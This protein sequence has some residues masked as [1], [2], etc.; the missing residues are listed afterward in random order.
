MCPCVCGENEKETLKRAFVR[1][2]KWKMAKANGKWSIQ[3]A[4]VQTIGNNDNAKLSKNTEKVNNR[5]R[6]DEQKKNN[7]NEKYKKN[8]FKSKY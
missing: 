5:K 2:N 6:R 1:G 7:N 3:A 4:K 8:N